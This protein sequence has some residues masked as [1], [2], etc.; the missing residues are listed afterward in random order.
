MH[1]GDKKQIEK[2]ELVLVVYKHGTPKKNAFDYNVTSIRKCQFFNPSIL[3]MILKKP[4]KYF[5][6]ILKNE[7]EE[8]Y[9]ELTIKNVDGWKNIDIY[10]YKNVT[11]KKD[12][13]YF[14]H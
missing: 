12:E 5:N 14:L 4:K 6:D 7:P 2:N 1:Y 9:Y 10:S 13:L 11:D 3:K 8:Q